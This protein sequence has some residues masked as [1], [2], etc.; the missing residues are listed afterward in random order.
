MWFIA[1]TLFARGDIFSDSFD[2]VRPVKVLAD[3]AICL[4]KP[5]MSSRGSVMKFLQNL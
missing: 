5:E 4:V 3:A 2:H 1:L